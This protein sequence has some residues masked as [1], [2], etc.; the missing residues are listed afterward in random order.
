M[1]LSV[2][3][4]L[5]LDDPWGPFQ[6]KPFYDLL[7]RLAEGQEVPE[8][9]LWSSLQLQKISGSLS[10]LAFFPPR[11]SLSVFTELVGKSVCITGLIANSLVLS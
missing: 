10:L 4:R 5:K 9:P 3:G 1:A 6:P 11:K 7:C 8:R 2:V